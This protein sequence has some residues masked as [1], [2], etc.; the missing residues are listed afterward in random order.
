MS[1]TT[2][3]G[4]AADNQSL[5]LGE[6]APWHIVMS[7]SQGARGPREILAWYADGVLAAGDYTDE[8]SL[9]VAPLDLDG[10]TVLRVPVPRDA[11]LLD[12]QAAETWFAMQAA[13]DELLRCSRC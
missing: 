1:R 7:D 2:T 12:E 3:F 6:E 4:E 13:D 8:P 9:Y 5:R 10:N 11:V